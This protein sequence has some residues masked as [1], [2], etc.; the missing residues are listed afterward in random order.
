MIKYI[1]YTCITMSYYC[2]QYPIMY[3]KFDSKMCFDLLNM[4]FTKFHPLL[5]LYY[6]I[7][8]V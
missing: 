8:T 6:I 7:N 5:K 4:N 1:S 2:V 3:D